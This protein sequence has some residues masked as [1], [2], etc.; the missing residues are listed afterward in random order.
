M[1]KYK[2]KI[3]FHWRARTWW[4]DRFGENEEAIPALP[5]TIPHIRSSHFLRILSHYFGSFVLSFEMKWGSSPN[6]K[7]GSSQNCWIVVTKVQKGP[8]YL[9]NHK[10]F[11]SWLCKIVKLLLITISKSSDTLLPLPL[12]LCEKDLVP[13]IKAS[14]LETNYFF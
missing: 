2:Q 12:S 9:P 13:T 1:E 4:I 7:L 14:L 11:A 8:T 6:H 5:Y 3:A 10:V